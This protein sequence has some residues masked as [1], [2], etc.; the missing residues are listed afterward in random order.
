MAIEEVDG[1]EDDYPARINPLW[2]RR[3]IT[4][5][6]ALHSV[7]DAAQPGPDHAG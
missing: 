6:L 5:S 1:L 4:V 7:D 3:S 2:V